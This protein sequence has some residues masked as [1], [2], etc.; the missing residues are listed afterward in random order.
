MACLLPFKESPESGDL[1]TPDP[2]PSPKTQE[3]VV[4]ARDYTMSEWLK[5]TAVL[6]NINELT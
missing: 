3:K 4:W 6:N 1:V 5:H 2:F